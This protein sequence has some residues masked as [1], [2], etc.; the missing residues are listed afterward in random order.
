MTGKVENGTKRAANV[1]FRVTPPK[2][3]LLLLYKSKGVTH[4]NMF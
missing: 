1:K 3:I 4:L 2:R